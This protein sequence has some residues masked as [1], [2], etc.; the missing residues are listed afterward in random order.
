MSV[1]TK[2][3]HLNSKKIIENIPWRLSDEDLPNIEADSFFEDSDNLDFELDDGTST[4]SSVNKEQVNTILDIE[5]K[6]DSLQELPKI[7][8]E[9]QNIEYDEGL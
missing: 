5:Q 8:E 2:D 1:N 6:D 7:Q 9:L 3:G 4:Y